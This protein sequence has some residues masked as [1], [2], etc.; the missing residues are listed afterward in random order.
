MGLLTTVIGL[1]SGDCDW[2]AEGVLVLDGAHFDIGSLSHGET[3]ALEVFV[4]EVHAP[5]FLS[6]QV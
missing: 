5:Q 2:A 4:K 3:V 6:I 1:L